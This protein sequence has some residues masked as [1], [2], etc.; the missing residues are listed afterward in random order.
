MIM[1]SLLLDFSGQK[2]IKFIFSE[3]LFFTKMLITKGG[4]RDAM[5][6]PKRSPVI[7]SL[8]NWREITM[9]QS[10]VTNEIWQNTI[11]KAIHKASNLV[12]SH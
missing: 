1:E 5:R 7:N 11:L 4:L 6:K 8:S 9:I 2:K 3:V 10:E 12:G